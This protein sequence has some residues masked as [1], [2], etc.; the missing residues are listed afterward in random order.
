MTRATQ[1]KELAAA[2]AVEWFLRQQDASLPTNDRRAYAEWLLQSP[3][4][5]EEY[6]AVSMAW[7]VTGATD[8]RAKYSRGALLAAA[9]AE[10]A[11]DNVVPLDRLA[12]R[13]YPRL[14]APAA[15]RHAWARAVVAVVLIGVG[16]VSAWLLTSAPEYTTGHGEQR[17]VLLADGS[18]ITLNTDS[19]VRVRFETRERAIELLRGEARFRVAKDA[20]RPFVVTADGTQV[21]ALGTVFNVR[22]DDNRT[23][24]SVVEGHVAVTVVDDA[25]VGTV[26]STSGG[27]RAAASEQLREV[28]LHTGERATVG[29]GSVR[30]GMGQPIEVVN[31]WT[32]R[33]LVF[34][35][36]TLASVIAEFNRYRMH[37]LVLD[38]PELGSLKI[39]GVINIEDQDSLLSYLKNFETVGIRRYADGSE[40]LVGSEG[41]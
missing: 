14:R 17:S 24:I 23:Q 37:P 40:H 2:E 34:R 18:V 39:S 35:D 12:S 19:R 11:A 8:G 20:G 26:S 6:L 28:E 7:A 10:L 16:L 21:R 13:E 15:E 33:K 38:D 41:N 32:E 31:A 9:S 25:D 4:H 29:A 5:I 30:V 27:S 36:E 1:S 3:L 22:V